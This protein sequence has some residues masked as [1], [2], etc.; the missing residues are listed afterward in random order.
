LA[1]DGFLASL[2]EALSIRI[3]E[4]SLPDQEDSGLVMR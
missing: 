2:D 4:S 1:E 3:I